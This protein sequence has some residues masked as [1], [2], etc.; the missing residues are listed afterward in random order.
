[1]HTH[2]GR[3]VFVSYSR[4]DFYAA[5]ALTSVL[6]ASGRVRPWLDVENL[7]PGT[8]WETAINGAI[9]SADAVVVVASPD[10]MA[11]RWVTEEWQRALR[12]G[13]QVHVALV[14]KTGLPPELASA[15]VH[16]LR[17]R[18]FAEARRLVEIL[19]GQAAPRARRRFPM[20][21]PM[22][23][24][25]SSLVFCTLIVGL[26]ATL[27]WDLSQVY[28]PKHAG[29][30]QIGLSFALMNA[31]G[32]AGLIYLMVRLFRRSVS[33]TSL[34]E[35]F[36]VVLVCV[37]FS[38]IG[39]WMVGSRSYREL[40]GPDAWSDSPW[41][42]VAAAAVAV[43]G[44]ALV[45]YSRTVNLQ[46]PTGKGQDHL[47][48]RVNGRRARRRARRFGHLWA[49]YQPKLAALKRALP[50]VG[51]T[52]SY[53][54]WCQPE[55]TPLS[56]LITHA[57]DRAGF[58]KDEADPRWVFVVVT[59]RTPDEVVRNAHEVHGDR[60]VFVLATSLRVLDDELRRHQWLDFR[61]QDP[62]GVY[63]FL[64]MAITGR[65]AE[66]GVVTVPMGID[67]FRAPGYVTGYLVFG[68]VLLSLAVAPPLGLLIAGAFA[69]AV[70][71]V[72]VTATLAAAMISLMRGTAARSFDAVG[73]FGRTVLVFLL[74][75]AWLVIA[76]NPPGIPPI[77]RVF[78]FV[79]VVAG[80]CVSMKALLGLWLPPERGP[81]APAPAATAPVVP[82]VYTLSFSLV[83][84]VLAA[85]FFAV[86]A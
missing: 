61:E 73:W 5:E 13:K 28:R 81:V 77:N 14:R 41:P 19:T 9:D 24:L 84:L 12:A 65:P 76:P 17:G 69:R 43:L 27:G 23:L 58:V 68:R 75:I 67:R 74:F 80:L 15:V 1:V 30:A 53:W 11:S 40:A 8:D 36:F 7:R 21:V 52:G 20:S 39:T 82:P 22:A 31:V 62:E 25:W 86:V 42:Y 85:G 29:M 71:V 33:P 48:L 83:S 51:S 38:L 10:A 46:M 50:G 35:G 3:N 18:F 6:A 63:E 45:S 57:C 49:G 47:R 2:F 37:M 70:P 4:R 72:L 64:R 44:I 79:F 54:V 59:T 32:V 16:D 55:D 78:L 66:R 34:R 60:V 26:G 56:V